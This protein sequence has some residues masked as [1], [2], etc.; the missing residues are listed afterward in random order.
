M[1][2][3]LFTHSFPYAFANEQTFLEREIPF[4]IDIFDCVILIPKIS[5]GRLLPIPNSVKIEKGF[6]DYYKKNCNIFSFVIN[7]L[8]YPLFF[9][10]LFANLALVF[11][12]FK[13]IRLFIYSGR[14]VLIQKWFTAWLENCQIHD[15]EIILYTYWFD[16]LTTSL[17]LVKQTYPQLKL[18]S[19]AHG[20]DIY[21][22]LYFPYYWPMRQKTLSMLDKLFLASFDG[23]EYF[24]K[25]FPENHDLFET[26]HLG[27]SDP[28]FLSQASSDGVL[29][30][31]SCGHILPLK[32][33]DLLCD[34]IILAAEMRPEIKF[35]WNHF[36]DGKSRR[37]IIKQ[38]NKRFPINAKGNL[39]G[40]VPNRTVM[41]HYKNH[42]VDVFVNLST[43][44]GGA[45]VSIQEAIA[46]GIPV[47]ATQVGGNP[48]IVSEGNGILLVENPTTEEVARALIRMNDKPEMASK[49]RN[50][51]RKV[52]KESF[53]AEVNFQIFADK[54]KSI[55]QSS[56]G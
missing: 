25:H 29:R 11:Q 30:I 39:P 14:V 34:G 37:K 26:A 19:R 53:N 43:T 22:N 33:I 24:R 42:P 38:I 41:Q 49:M 56:Q 18:I 3:L 9:Q 35:E 36:G 27:I 21:E 32:R 1:K 47:I 28:G 17:G 6:S 55:R 44:E 48:E 20:Y 10:E 51:S 13:L 5:K 16:E 7:S 31:I 4:F 12:P 15:E 23:R 50:E 8:S 46:C 40:N 54:V 52:W 2:V 45:P